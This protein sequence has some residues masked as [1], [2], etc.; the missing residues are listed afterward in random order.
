M[1]RPPTQDK[2]MKE[3]R[4]A[5]NETSL[6]V[7]VSRMIREDFRL[8]ANHL[9]LS[10]PQWRVLLCVSR[11]PGITPKAMAEALEVSAVTITQSVDRLE[12][13]GWLRKQRQADDRRWVK[14]Y[15]TK[16]AGPVVTELNEIGE[17]MRESMLES[18]SDRER[19]QL[20]KLLSKLKLNLGRSLGNTLT[21]EE[22]SD[23][24]DGK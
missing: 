24:A 8:R 9:K 5:D 17:E 15:A 2:W 16:N 1:Q 14:L 4:E 23:V 3:A 13:A 20:T 7:D 10:Q 6:V 19:K 18:F 22:E 21:A 11:N 12:K